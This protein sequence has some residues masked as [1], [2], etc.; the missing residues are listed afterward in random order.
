MTVLGVHGQG[1]FSEFLE[2]YIVGWIKHKTSLDTFTEGAE[3]F[4]AGQV[5]D[6]ASSAIERSEVPGRACQM[7]YCLPPSDD[8]LLDSVASGSTNEVHCGVLDQLSSVVVA[9]PIVSVE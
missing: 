2:W 9:T 1:E 8:I 4:V 3:G 5:V 7:V 6:K